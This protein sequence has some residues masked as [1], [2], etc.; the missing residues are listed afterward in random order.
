ESNR[1]LADRTIDRI[2][3]VRTDRPYLA[4]TVAEAAARFGDRPAFVDPDGSVLT[5]TGL[6]QRSDEVAAGL[7]RRGIG[8][9]DV[10][11][12]T[13]PSTTA[14]VIAYAAIA[15]VG[16]PEAGVNPRLTTHERQACL[17]Q[18]SPSLVLDDADMVHTLAVTGSRP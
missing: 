11:A 2:Q 9:G 17:D 18:V 6:H 5:Y 7:A 12:L 4:A 10:V 16:A 15:K 13:L 3:P 1:G 14:W 8:I